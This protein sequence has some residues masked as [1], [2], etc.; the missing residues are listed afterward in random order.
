M[1]FTAYGYQGSEVFGLDVVNGELTNYSNSSACEEAEGV[2]T[3]GTSVLV[4]RDLESTTSP[5]PLDIWRLDLDGGTWERLTTF[6]RYAPFYASSPAVAPD[7]ERFAF[8]LSIDGDSEG[9]GDGIL[10]SDL[11][12][13]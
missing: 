12:P 6:N 8:Q 7:G 4:E 13:A 10:L 1:I 3:D 2:D 11:A 5:G 9:E